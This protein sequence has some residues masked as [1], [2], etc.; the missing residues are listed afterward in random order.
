MAA[1]IYPRSRQPRPP[2]RNIPLK[3]YK[4]SLENW[5]DSRGQDLLQ[6]SVVGNID[7]NE[8]SAALATSTV[9]I[10]I[11]SS[12]RL[13]ENYAELYP[14]NRWMDTETYRRQP[15][16]RRFQQVT[17]DLSRGFLGQLFIEQTADNEVEVVHLGNRVE[18]NKQYFNDATANHMLRIIESLAELKSR[19]VTSTVPGWTRKAPSRLSGAMRDVIPVGSFSHFHVP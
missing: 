6:V 19:T 7:K 12:I 11:P 8:T 1:P 17:R 5:E 9:R 14:S 10:P 3:I 2:G 16:F 18:G 13:V 4:G 15:S